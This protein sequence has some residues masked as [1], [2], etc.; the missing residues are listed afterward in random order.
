MLSF[1]LAS[2]RHRLRI[3]VIAAAALVACF[4]YVGQAGAA[5]YILFNGFVFDTDGVTPADAMVVVHYPAYP[6]GIATDTY[7]DG[8]FMPYGYYLINGTRSGGMATIYAYTYNLNADH[9]Y[10]DRKSQEVVINL[11][12]IASDSH[13]MRNLTLQALPHEPEPV[14]TFRGRITRSGREAAFAHV[15][16]A[17]GSYLYDRTASDPGYYD[18]QLSYV[19]RPA[20]MW[21]TCDGYES[22]HWTTATSAGGTVYHDWDLPLPPPISSPPPPVSPTPR[23]CPT[24]SPVPVK[25]YITYTGRVCVDGVPVKDAGVF[26]TYSGQTT[27]VVTNDTG[28]YLITMA[29]GGGQATLWAS[30]FGITSAQYPV[31]PAH[32][33]IVNHSF[34]IGTGSQSTPAPSP[35]ANAP[36]ATVAPGASAVTV[37]PS[38]LPAVSAMPPA[39]P[40]DRDWPLAGWN[41]D[42]PGFLM[43]AAIVA[44]SII[45]VLLVLYCLAVLIVTRL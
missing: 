14:V 9:S 32:G 34:D 15:F 12:E 22:P 29:N 42:L 36:A 1:S 31:F 5:D 8:T 24:P 41:I 18:F 40:G 7:M 39:A 19:N 45:A 3:A 13:V 38:P 20:E 23:P 26:C 17:Y 10:M 43:G 25:P 28:S 30:Y 2:R 11:D 33:S 6:E 37:T 27:G 21:V 4:G 35:T 44:G 16:V